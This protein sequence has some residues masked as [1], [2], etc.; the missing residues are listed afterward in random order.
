MLL[1][2]TPMAVWKTEKM[3]SIILQTTVRFRKWPAE[4][5]GKTLLSVNIV[6]IYIKLLYDYLHYKT[7]IC[8]QFSVQYSTLL[9]VLFSLSRGWCAIWLCGGGTGKHLQSSGKCSSIQTSP[10][11]WEVGCNVLWKHCGLRHP[12]NL[13]HSGCSREGFLVRL[14]KLGSSSQAAETH[15]GMDVL[16]VSCNSSMGW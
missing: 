1:A 14:I 2:W 7:C 8:F 5:S 9:S 6:Y 13:R 10:Q 15:L 3:I 4:R 12:S 16:T 11:F